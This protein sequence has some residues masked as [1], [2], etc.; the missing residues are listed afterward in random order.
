MRFNAI[1]FSAILLVAGLAQADTTHMRIMFAGSPSGE[2]TFELNPDG[3]FK[4]TTK[5]VIG[6]ITLQSDITGKFEGGRIVQ[7]ESHNVSATGTRS[8]LTL[9]AGKL[10]LQSG[11][12]DRDLD[13]K[14]GQG[15]YFGN[16]HPQLTISALESVDFTKKTAQEIKVFSP[17][18]GAMLAPRFT[19]MEPRKIARGMVREID[20]VLAPVEATYAIDDSHHVLLMEVPGQKLKF[21]ADGWEALA[22]DPLAAYPELSQPD[23]KPITER[24]VKMRARDGVTLVQDV[25]RPDAPGKFPVILERTPYG[26]QAAEVEGP[27][28]ARRGYIF[29]TQDC[30]GRGDSNGEWDPFVHERKDGYDAVQWAA[31]QPW[32]DGNVGM[33]GGSYGGVVQWEAAVERP[34]ALK[35]IIP[36]VSPPDAFYNL[37]Y[38][39]G[40]FFL[41]GSLWWAKIVSSRTID[42]SSFMSKLPNPEKFATLPLSK[43]DKAVLGGQVPFYSKWLA[44]TGANDWAGFN[45]EDD[46]KKVTIPALHIS[47]WWDGDEIGTMLNWAKMRALGR[48]NQWLVYGPWTHLFNTA[49]KIGDTD[50]GPDA[51]IDLDSINLRWFDTWLK[52]KNVGMDKI[53]HVRA[54][55]TGT[56]KWVESR[57]WPLSGSKTATLYLGGTGTI[58]GSGSTGTLDWKAPKGQAPSKYQFDPHNATIDKRIL[59]PDP[60]KATMNVK[61]PKKAPGVTMFKSAPL[62]ETMTI[63][64]PITLDLRFST[65]AQSTDFFAQLLDVDAQEGY[66]IVGQPGKFRCSYLGGFDKPRA[67]KPGKIYQ[68][69]FQI[70]DT[71]HAFPKGHRVC[72]LLTSVMFPVYSRNLGTIEPIATGTKMVVQNQKIYHDTKNPSSVTFQVL[73]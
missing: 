4:S 60:N 32:S 36:Q 45:Y 50:F 64:G 30:R 31:R 72:L 54:F 38:D 1:A 42:L 65:S 52:H 14:V 63:A 7:Y 24:G 53:P 8:T 12:I 35:C 16:L 18:V 29:V 59:D 13:L 33:I 67:L 44:R 20:M 46:L 71:A 5:L 34:P 17:D 3:T 58:E 57:D 48:T 43:L 23:Y 47:G 40:V 39:N 22:K 6:S 2:N 49:S 26:R 27:F 61:F 56:N 9:N 10:H 19:P 70:W 62:K 68:C 66:K 41:Y 69:K 55:V 11:K 15:P 51:V 25:I 73:R 28:Y 37:P 21:I